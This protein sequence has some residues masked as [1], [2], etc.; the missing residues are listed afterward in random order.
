MSKY[1]IVVMS[2]TGEA[3]P[4]GQGRMV[5]AMTTVRELNAAGHEASLWFHGIGVTWLAAFDARTDPFSQH[6]G[7]LFDEVRSAIGGS[8]EFCTKMRFGA[9]ASA[10]HL[11]VAPVG[12]TKDH[13]TVATLLS[14]GHQVLTF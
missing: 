14:E 10:D 12:G 9:A 7:P 6:Y 8:C 5:H 1:A 13:H 3:N 4:G 2:E 11:G